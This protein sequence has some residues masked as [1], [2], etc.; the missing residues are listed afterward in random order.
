MSVFMS[1]VSSSARSGPCSSVDS[2]SSSVLSITRGRWLE[3]S[4][5]CQMADKMMR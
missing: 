1:I 3:R 2:R 5:F 4:T